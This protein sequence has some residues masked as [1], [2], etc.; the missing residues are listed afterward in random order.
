MKVLYVVLIFILFI[1]CSSGDDMNI[2]NNDGNNEA[3]NQSNNRGEIE[4]VELGVF[5]SDDHTTTGMASINSNGT[6]LSFKNFETDDGPKLLV[7]LSTDKN[8]TDYVDLGELKGIKGDFDYAIPENTDL[9]KYIVVS[10]WCV[11]FS[12]SFGHAVLK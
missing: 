4:I 12:V 7:Y 9:N 6:I 3:G 1:S 8:S 10:I 2:I 11:D 5:V